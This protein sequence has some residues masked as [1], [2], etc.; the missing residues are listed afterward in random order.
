[1]LDASQSLLELSNVRSG[2]KWKWPLV[3]SLLSA[4]F[5]ALATMAV[6]QGMAWRGGLTG[7]L[8]PGTNEL[9]DWH[10]LGGVP[11][12]KE[13]CQYA[14][15]KYL[16]MAYD[17]AKG[18]PQPWWSKTMEGDIGDPG[19]KVRPVYELNM[20]SESCGADVILAEECADAM[21]VEVDEI[22]T[23]Y[24]FQS[25]LKAQF[26][27]GAF[28]DDFGAGFSFTQSAEF[29]FINRHAKNFRFT[30]SSAVCN[31][32][33][34]VVQGGT[35]LSKE[36]RADVE[37]LPKMPENY[38]QGD[39]AYEQF[40]DDC[41]TH[42]SKTIYMG[43]RVS[44][45]RQ[46]EEKAL[47]EELRG[48]FDLKA[49]VKADLKFAH[50][51]A[52]D[53]VS[54][55]GHS[56]S[57][58]RHQAVAKYD[59]CVGAHGICP[60]NITLAQ[61]HRA[62]VQDPMPLEATFESIL[63]LFTT[64]H[65]NA[66]IDEKRKHLAK[67]IIKKYCRGKLQCN[68]VVPEIYSTEVH[69]LSSGSPVST[70]VSLQG[71][72]YV[73]TQGLF[74]WYR[75]NSRWW[76]SCEGVEGSPHIF[77]YS[78]N[79]WEELSG[80]SFP[81]LGGFAL[82]ASSERI[83][84]VGGLVD[85]SKSCSSYWSSKR[86]HEIDLANEQVRSIGELSQSRIWLA[87]VVLND[88]WLYAIGG[89]LHQQKG[90]HWKAFGLSSAEA[91]NVRTNELRQTPNMLEARIWPA[92]ATLDGSIF[93]AVGCRWNSGGRDIKDVLPTAEYL[94]ASSS[95]WIP[96]EEILSV[97]RAGASMVLSH[98]QLL[99][100][101]GFTWNG[102]LGRYQSLED[103]EVL[104]STNAGNKSSLLAW[105]KHMHGR[106]MTEPRAW[107]AAVEASDS[108]ETN[109]VFLV[110]GLTDVYNRHSE[111]RRVEVWS[112]PNVA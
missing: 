112:L 48:G 5:L 90:T 44:R 92:V 54:A 109:R 42:F 102:N 56:G 82:A 18:M 14:N 46:F 106:L 17:L 20:D 111:A 100:F 75:T 76:Q 83:F 78:H 3:I 98:G 94:H 4:G 11:A 91:F 45:F 55:K 31:V 49:A 22:A 57:F 36:F 7:K 40:V 88:E 97:P 73:A 51:E 33:H 99:V 72:T 110:G 87:A 80:I 27:A 79:G 53:S 101:G 59:V 8:A 67:Y 6:M 86:I 68:M 104:P 39:V 15:I 61:W 37:A 47:N 105:R 52:D 107:M 25:K 85:R 62:A 65:F 66:D 58:I 38:D 41:G 16:G 12:T 1:M 63:A 21:E 70:A 96:L 93:V 43:T 26:S 95:R 103:V 28:I 19:W 77:K 35:Q 24:D 32:Y 13:R 9:L 50:A 10:H 23:G 81:R 84:V 60:P 29:G 2:R 71:T 89:A 69:E 34:A 74:I 30:W 108:R 64:H